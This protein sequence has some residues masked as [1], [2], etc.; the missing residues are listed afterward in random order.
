VTAGATT[1]S[2]FRDSSSD[3][4][5]QDQGDNDAVFSV[6]TDETAELHETVPVHVP[7]KSGAPN[8]PKKVV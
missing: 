7:A 4:Q 8:C 3:E 6:A 5:D 1:S 2:D